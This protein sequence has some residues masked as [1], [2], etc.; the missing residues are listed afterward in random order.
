MKQA[1]WSG[2]VALLM[3]GVLRAEL[4]PSVYEAKQKEAPEKIWIEVLRVDIESGEQAD[5]QKVGV[6]ALVTRVDRT[7]SGLQP[8]QVI[9]ISYVITE[10]PRGFVGPGEIPLLQEGE[11]TVAFLAREDSEPVYLPVAGTM[12][13]REF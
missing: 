3:A 5:Q 12:S 10:R 7:S 9:N 11:K 6:V 2:V 8:D 13:F 1:I 4:P